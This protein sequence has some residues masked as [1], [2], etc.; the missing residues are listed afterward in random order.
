MFQEQLSHKTLSSILNELH[1]V[2]KCSICLSLLQPPISLCQNG[3]GICKKCKQTLSECPTCRASFSNVHPIIL[4]NIINALPKVCINRNHGCNHVSLN[5]PDD[6]H[7]AV[8]PMRIVPCR[9]KVCKWTGKAN[10]LLQHFKTEHNTHIFNENSNV[11][12]CVKPSNKNRLLISP[13]SAFGCIFWKHAKLDVKK[14]K[15]F[16]FFHCIPT[17]KNF[18]DEFYSIVTFS[19]EDTPIEYKYS[20]KCLTGDINCFKVLEE[21][22]CMAVPFSTLPLFIDSE[23]VLKYKFCIVKFK[24]DCLQ[25]TF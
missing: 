1:E 13:V 18:V 6:D 24:V 3:H 15:L 16:I 12:W 25:N 10:G 4:E 17:S 5:L 2:A 8:C 20:Q 9:I 14:K 21:E 19:K 7:E 22:N 11:R 23:S